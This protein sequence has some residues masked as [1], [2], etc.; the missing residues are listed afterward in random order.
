MVMKVGLT[1]NFVVLYLAFGFWAILSI[2]VLLCMEGMSAFLH[3]LRLHWVEFNNKF[4]VAEGYP[5][6]PFAYKK[7]F[8]AD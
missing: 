2:A 5:F 3:A 7:I 4:Y 8:E 1:G 6:V